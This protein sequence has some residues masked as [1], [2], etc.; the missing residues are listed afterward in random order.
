MSVTVIVSVFFVVANFLVDVLY[1]YL[2]PRLR[3][4]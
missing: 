2:D 3:A 1:L 4:A